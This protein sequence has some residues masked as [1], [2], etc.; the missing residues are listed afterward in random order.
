MDKSRSPLGQEKKI[1][2]EELA[3]MFGGEIPMEA[4]QFIF[5]TAP[6]DMTIRDARNHLEEMAERYSS[7]NAMVERVA[8][9]LWDAKAA[10]LENG[11]QARALA[12]A[13]LK[14]IGLLSSSEPKVSG[15][16]DH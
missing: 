4:M 15:S 8:A 13:A 16:N 6:K 1:G 9:A 14:E 5:V 10:P 3:E 12:K 7:E 11:M 2:I